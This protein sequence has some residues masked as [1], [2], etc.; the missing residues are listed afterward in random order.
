MAQV[1]EMNV[2]HLCLAVSFPPPHS[3]LLCLGSPT[4]PSRLHP[5]FTALKSSRFA[6]WIL[7]H[8]STLSG[9][10]EPLISSLRWKNRKIGIR[11]VGV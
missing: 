1:T 8:A 9:W 7:P 5:L 11:D 6:A 10:K 3:I 4:P 2:L